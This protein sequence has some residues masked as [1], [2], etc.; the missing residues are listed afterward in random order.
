M[1]DT[2]QGNG[3]NGRHT[4]GGTQN[5]R[6]VNQQSIQ[7]QN[8]NFIGFDD[9]LKLLLSPTEIRD[10][11]QFIEFKES[12]IGHVLENFNHPADIVKFINTGLI[13]MIPLL[14]F[15]NIMKEY[16]FTNSDALTTEGKES[17]SSLLTN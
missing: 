1:S 7:H 2:D 9:S 6:G 8:S 4:R 17:L 16:G 12:I 11:F 13:P 14:T 5:N 3:D 15:T 10:K